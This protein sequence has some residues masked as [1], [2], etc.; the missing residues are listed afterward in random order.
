MSKVLEI[1][2]KRVLESAEQLRK[3][4]EKFG[5]QLNN[6]LHEI[7]TYYSRPDIDFMKTVECL[8]VRQRDGF[9]EI[10]YKPATTAKSHTTEDVIIKPETNLSI[11]ADDAP[12]AKQLL[13]NIGM[14]K[15]VEVDK[16]RSAFQSP[17]F[18]GATIAID[19]VKLAGTFVEVEI[20]SE[21]RKRAISLIDDLEAKLGL[22]DARIVTKPYR[23]LCME[24]QD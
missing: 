10:T 9:A 16:S 21:N 14:V 12:V 23:D 20:L 15:L 11:G 5:F 6:T 24:V 3:L 7:D 17:D 18:P 13:T 1:E 4:L 22:T 2:R 19:E 8:R